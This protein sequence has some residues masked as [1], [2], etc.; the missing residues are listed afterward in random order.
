ME[1]ITCLIKRVCVCASSPCV[2][3]CADVTIVL[4]GSPAAPS[5]FVNGHCQDAS[6]AGAVDVAVIGNTLF[7]TDTPNNAVRAIDLATGA[8]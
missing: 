8:V 5:P 1:M 4:C 2:R 3:V 7:V 6:F